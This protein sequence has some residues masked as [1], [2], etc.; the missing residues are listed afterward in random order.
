M[1]MSSLSF[2]AARGSREDTLQAGHAARPAPD[3]L[4]FAR[5]MT[6]HDGVRMTGGRATAMLPARRTGQ[7]QGL[8][9]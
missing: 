3:V 1:N 6:P 7:E 8:A 4:L 2:P 9:R 5:I